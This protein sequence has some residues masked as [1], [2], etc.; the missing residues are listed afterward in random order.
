M[1]RVVRQYERGVILRLGR[2][3]PEPKAPGMRLVLPLVDRMHRVSLR[4]VTLPVESQKIITRDSVSIDV[5]AVAYYQV[6]DPMRAILEIE[7]VQSAIY[8]IA[9]TTVRNVVGQSSLDDVLAAT[10]KINIAI[11]KILDEATEPWGVQIRL[12]ELKDIQLPATMQR[13]MAREAEAEREKRG[14]IIAAEGE[15][16]SADKLSQ[17][18]AVIAREPVALQLRNLQVL[19]E[20]AVEKNSTVIFPSQF[21]TTLDDIRRGLQPGGAGRPSPTA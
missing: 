1:F 7:D 5:A 11:R 14:K 18:A 9:Q 17:A 12:V 16:L 8:E 2:A 6:V 4:I 19:A 15:L 10:E 3:R 21:M 20:I 13:A